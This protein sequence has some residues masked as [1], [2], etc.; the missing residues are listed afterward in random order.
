MVVGLGWWLIPPAV[1]IAHSWLSVTVPPSPCGLATC[2]GA[3]AKRGISSSKLCLPWAWFEFWVISVWVSSCSRFWTLWTPL[4]LQWAHA[5]GS[6]MGPF[7]SPPSPSTGLSLPVYY[8]EAAFTL[9]CGC[10]QPTPLSLGLQSLPP[11][12]WGGFFA[13]AS[14]CAMP[15]LLLAFL[16]LGL[17]TWLP[18]TGHTHSATIP[19]MNGVRATQ[20]GVPLS[21]AFPWFFHHT[22][23]TWPPWVLSP[24]PH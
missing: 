19:V 20:T 5:V 9:P 11:H 2:S 22:A 14:L 18:S 16:F 13:A 6:T 21:P 23:F 10:L 1:G 8:H 3:Q 4:G 15:P 24:T 17:S 7:W 12:F